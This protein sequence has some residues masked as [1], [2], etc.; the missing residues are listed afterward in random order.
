[1]PR[2][3]IPRTPALLDGLLARARRR[4]AERLAR[5]RLHAL[6]DHLLRDIGL[7]RASIDR[8]LREGRR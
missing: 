3:P 6:D 1:M 4:H 7:D 5:H 8:A 2:H